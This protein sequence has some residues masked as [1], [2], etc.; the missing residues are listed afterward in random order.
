MAAVSRGAERTAPCSQQLPVFR[1]AA[2]AS[3]WFLWLSVQGCGEPVPSG[4]LQILPPL[5]LLAAWCWGRGSALHRLLLVS[6]SHGPCSHL[7][8]AEGAA[9][10]RM[11]VCSPAGAVFPLSWP[12]PSHAQQA[13]PCQEMRPVWHIRHAEQRPGIDRG[14]W[15]ESAL[16]APASCNFMHLP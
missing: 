12:C 1:N 10:W 7:A 4:Q 3:H 11:L 14:P 9:C 16:A 8:G 2:A 5:S 13:G 15:M 6:V